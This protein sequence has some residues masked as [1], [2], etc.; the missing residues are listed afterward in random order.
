MADIQVMGV[1]PDRPAAERV[2]GNLRLAG[3][4][5][6]TVDLI[7]V[8]RDEAPEALEQ[9]DD[10][11]GEGAG[12]VASSVLRGA[13]VGALIGLVLGVGTLFIPGLQVLSPVI[14]VVLFVGSC[15]FVGA[16]SGA[17]ASEDTSEEVINRYGMALRE[18]QAVIRVLAPNADTAKDAENMLSA[19]GATNVNSYLQDDTKITDTPGVEEVSAR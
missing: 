14:L 9:I 17:F 12:I 15:A 19:A 16:L 8:R 2:V 4:P 5:S 3:F 10:Q 18:G 6:E 1:C 7:V 11:R 13:G